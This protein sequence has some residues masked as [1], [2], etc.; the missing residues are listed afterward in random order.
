M[1]THTDVDVL[2][3]T[4][5][6]NATF[7][8]DGKMENNLGATLPGQHFFILHI[9]MYALW[10]NKSIR[11]KIILLC[12][13]CVFKYNLYLLFV[14]TGYKLSKALCFICHIAVPCML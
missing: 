6:L 4:V 11:L 9:I 14:L 1:G 5:A 12:A 2:M 8:I 7:K 13:K 10:Q 3:K